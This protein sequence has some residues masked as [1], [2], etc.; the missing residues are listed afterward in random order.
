MFAP[1]EDRWTPR[2]YVSGDRRPV[3]IFFRRLES[4]DR[5]ALVEF[6]TFLLPKLMDYGPQLGKPFLVQ[7]GV[8]GLLALCLDGR[9]RSYRVYLSFETGRSIVMY[10]AAACRASPFPQIEIARAYYNRARS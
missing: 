6:E 3:D 5:Q 8:R 10:T 9:R 7:T 4:T 2:A 1:A